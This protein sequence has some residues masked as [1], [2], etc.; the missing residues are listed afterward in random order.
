[1]AGHEPR[2]LTAVTLLAAF[3]IGC[4]PTSSP[5]NTPASQSTQPTPTRVATISPRTTQS[6]LA[7]A[8]SERLTLRSIGT[9]AN[10]PLGYAEYVPP[11]YGD[12]APRPLLVYLHS[13]TES[14]DGS[15]TDLENLLTDAVPGLIDRDE[16]PEDRPF[17]VLA[18]QHESVPDAMCVQPTEIADFL[19]FALEDYDVDPARIYLTA[20]SCGAVGAWQYLGL[21]TDEVVAGAVLI[22]GDGRSA[23]ADAACHLGL[24]PIWA[25]HG[26]ADP[27]VEPSGSIEPMTALEACTD[28]APV[29]AML[30]VFPGRGHL[31]WNTIYDGT[32]QEDIYAWLLEHSN[33][34]E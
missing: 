9:V 13:V 28:P 2:R 19:T 5:T 7:F 16:W 29:D 17:V 20:P 18:P 24:V 30:T 22:A 11:G 21:H 26:D 15:E 6:P 8:A 25:F 14:G 4:S 33:P 12:G 1:M 31:I 34:P 10:A 32:A 3:A 27:I 23:F